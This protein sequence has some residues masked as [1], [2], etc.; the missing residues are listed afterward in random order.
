M[1]VTAP[2][3][4]ELA[5]GLQVRCGGIWVCFRDAGTR[6]TC[7]SLRLHCKR[8]THQ[9]V[10]DQKYSSHKKSMSLFTSVESKSDENVTNC[11]RNQLFASAEEGN[12]AGEDAIAAVEMPEL[13]ASASVKSIEV[14]AWRGRKDQIPGG[15]ERPCPGRRQDAM[16]PLDLSRL[17]RHGNQ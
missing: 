9:T 1:T 11:N 7:R 5:P 10:G 15:R 12:R 14:P 8:P 4:I 17:R 13:L 6:L 16:L 2:A 3:N